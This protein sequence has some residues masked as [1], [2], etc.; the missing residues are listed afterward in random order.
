MGPGVFLYYPGHRQLMPKLRA[1]IDHV[2]TPLNRRQQGPRATIT[3]RRLELVI[4]SL[5]NDSEP[6]PIRPI[7]RYPGPSPCACSAARDCV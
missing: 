7:I 5:Q 4:S 2:K 6:M 3:Q 1:F